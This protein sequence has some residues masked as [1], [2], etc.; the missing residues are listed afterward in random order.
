MKSMRPPL[1]AIF[2]MTYFHR[3]RGGHGPLGPPPRIRY[4]V[5]DIAFA[6]F[7][8]IFCL[9]DTQMLGGNYARDLWCRYCDQ[10]DRSFL[11]RSFWRKSKGVNFATILCALAVITVH[12]LKRSNVL[13]TYPM[14]DQSNVSII[15]DIEHYISHTKYVTRIL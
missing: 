6:S 11:I 7:N 4:W 15:H 14:M 2:F 3:A 8:S 9:S 13:C 1:V 12:C 10:K 5:T